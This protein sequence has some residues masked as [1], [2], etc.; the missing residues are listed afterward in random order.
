[1]NGLATFSVFS[2]FLFLFVCLFVCSFVCLF[3]ARV[4]TRGKVLQ[5]SEN[6]D[7]ASVILGVLV[8][9]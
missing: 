9:K 5:V 2:L 1:M 7:I 6:E 4:R 3:I 8:E